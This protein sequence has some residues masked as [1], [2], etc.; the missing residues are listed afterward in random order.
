MLSPKNATDFW[1]LLFS[2]KARRGPFEGIH[3]G[4]HGDG[5]GVLYQEMDMILFAVALLEIRVE[6]GTD[7]FEAGA[8]R[9][10]DAPGD[11]FAAIL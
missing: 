11:G 10:Q 1:E 9:L 8:Q 5:W 7:F 2:D 4:R 6:V 3:N